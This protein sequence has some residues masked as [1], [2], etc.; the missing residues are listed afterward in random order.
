[1]KEGK[2]KKTKVVNTGSIVEK[3]KGLKELMDACAISKEEVDKA[4][5]KLLD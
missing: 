3:K 2:G 1:M 4:K 5:K